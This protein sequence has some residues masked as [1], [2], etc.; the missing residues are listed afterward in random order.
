MTDEFLK[1][2]DGI[3]M[4]QFLKKCYKEGS[5]ELEIELNPLIAMCQKSPKS[6]LVML[7]SC[8]QVLDKAFVAMKS[9]SGLGKKDMEMARILGALFAAY[10]VARNCYDQVPPELEPLLKEYPITMP[11]AYGIA[12]RL[13]EE[14]G[15]SKKKRKWKFW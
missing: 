6:A 15:F 8:A 7:R 11:F 5:E 2:D 13:M 1:S 3:W 4:R 10:S 9:A 14:A 12:I